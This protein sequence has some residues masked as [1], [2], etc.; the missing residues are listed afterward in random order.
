[1]PSPQAQAW[2]ECR[3]PSIPSAWPDMQLHAPGQ[4][5]LF[6]AMHSHSPQVAAAVH[7]HQAISPYMSQVHQH[8][9]MPPAASHVPHRQ[10]MQPHHQ[11][12]STSVPPWHYIQPYPQTPSPVSKRRHSHHGH[13]S[14]A[15]SPL[16]VAGQSPQH[17]QL[18]PPACHTP[19]HHQQALMMQQQ[20]PSHS[21]RHKDHKRQR[22]RSAS[23]SRKAP[24]KANHRSTSSSWADDIGLAFPGCFR[25]MGGKDL[26][27]YKSSQRAFPKVYKLV[28]LQHLA[29]HVIAATPRPPINGRVDY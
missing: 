19:P 6:Y 15:Q 29:P 14:A 20:A 7:G 23:T 4:R 13:S 28:I 9:P 10:H 25:S 12:V 3:H 16:Q 18:S 2:K 24:K 27:G 1:M 21:T 26:P 22:S 5:T 17:Q 11:H 8:Y